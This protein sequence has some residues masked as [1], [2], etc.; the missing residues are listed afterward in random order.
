M[1]SSGC[2]KVYMTSNLSRQFVGENSFKVY[3]THRSHFWKGG[4]WAADCRMEGETGKSSVYVCLTCLW[5]LL[6][7]FVNDCWQNLATR[8]FLWFQTAVLTPLHGSS[9]TL[10]LSHCFCKCL[11]LQCLKCECHPTVF[12]SEHRTCEHYTDG[13]IHEIILK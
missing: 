3:C 7:A 6:L 1:V 11:Q 10:D 5:I 12:R 2:Q 8:S 4:C 13:D 9:I